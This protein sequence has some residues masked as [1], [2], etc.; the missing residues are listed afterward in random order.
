[1][2]AQLAAPNPLLNRERLE[3][4]LLSP[5]IMMRM[6]PM[7]DIA[8]YIP[9]VMSDVVI[10]LYHGNKVSVDFSVIK[11]AG[12]AA[13]IL[14]ATQGTGFVDPA[15]APR[16]A[17]ARAAGL[18]VGAYHF[19][20]ATSPIEQV[21]HFLS[22]VGTSD[23]VLPVVDFEAYERSQPTVMQAAA[24]VMTIKSV[25]GRFP[26]L[27]TGRYMLAAP[28]FML[29][30]CPLWIAEYGSRPVCPPGWSTW[31]LWQH[32]DGRVGSAPVPVRGIGP[33]DRSSFAGT[34]DQLKAWWPVAGT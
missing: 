27:Y 15:F 19:L 13:V 1:M 5:V 3:C 31:K 32:T 28:N 25:T 29:S 23:G 11:S 26:V 30:Q 7:L 17:Q 4:G 24:A 22:V 14:K 9:P 20:D 34:I 12:I 33:C 18:L 10:D 8:P 21:G 6:A 16:I 2:N